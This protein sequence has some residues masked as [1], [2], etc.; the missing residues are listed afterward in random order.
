[1]P[2]RILIVDDDVELCEEIA[3]I[4]GDEGFFV[5]ICHEPLQCAEFIENNKYDFSI[6]DFKIPGSSGIELVK[7]IKQKIPDTKIIM[8]S[9]K[10]F[11]EKLKD[12]AAIS[13]FIDFVI[14]KPF[15]IEQ[16]LGIIKMEK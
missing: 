16:L 11:I 7:M 4:L 12:D 3:E 1:M 6:V 9:G 5:H 13:V 2:K 15:N 8:V 14:N 10:P